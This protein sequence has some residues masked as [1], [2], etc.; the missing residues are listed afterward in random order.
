MSHEISE[1]KLVINQTSLMVSATTVFEF[2]EDTDSI[3]IYTTVTNISNEDIVLEEVSS[4]CI[5]GVGGE[6]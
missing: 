3:R 2:F 1:N 6:N 4:V 5:D